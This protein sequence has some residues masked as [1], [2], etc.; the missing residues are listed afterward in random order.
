MRRP[1]RLD[2]VLIATC[3]LSIKLLYR[4]INMQLAAGAFTAGQLAAVTLAATFALAVLERLIKRWKVS[5]R[6][7]QQALCCR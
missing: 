4:S 5:L 6:A 3:R 1:S 7:L 2:F